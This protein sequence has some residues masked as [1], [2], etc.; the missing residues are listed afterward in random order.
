MGSQGSI[1]V[2]EVIKPFPFPF[3]TSSSTSS[4]A[5]GSPTFTPKMS[6]C[7]IIFLRM[8]L[9]DNAPKLFPVV[10]LHPVDLNLSIFVIPFVNLP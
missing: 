3:R 10:I 5:Q 6:S 4:G 1:S 8:G 7:V 9:F 2:G